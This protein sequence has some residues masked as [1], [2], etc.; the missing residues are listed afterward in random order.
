MVFFRFKPDHYPIY[1][2]VA[3]ACAG[4]V[5]YFVS[6]IPQT[7]GLSRYK[8]FL[9]KYKDGKEEGLDDE[10]NEII[11]KLGVE[12]DLEEST[13]QDIQPFITAN[14]NPITKGNLEWRFS[15]II[16]IPATFLC[17][18]VQDVK[19]SDLLVGGEEINWESKD[20]QNLADALT[21]SYRAKAFAIARE[22]EYSLSNSIVIISAI[23]SLAIIGAYCTGHFFNDRLQLKA[24]LPRQMRVGM[25]T[26]F[27][28]F[29]F[30]AYEVLK[31]TYICLL[32]AK[33]DREAAKLH[34]NIGKGG[35]EYYEKLQKRNIALRNLLKKEGEAYYSLFGNEK[36]SLMKPH[37]TL[38]ERTDIVKNI[39]DSFDYEKDLE[40]RNALK[41]RRNIDLFANMR[42]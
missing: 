29:Y 23:R 8:K 30:L 4:T 24:R 26:L 40:R 25:Y 10:L 19:K 42:F 5:T 21:L 9:Q 18:S 17:K 15:A 20:G 34:P 14:M 32:E 3:V 33:A 2:Q 22:M 28:G 13:K 37:L 39:V 16:G 41:E 31:D 1:W 7:L 6:A 36:H 27:A 38:T 35:L 12:L 11:Q